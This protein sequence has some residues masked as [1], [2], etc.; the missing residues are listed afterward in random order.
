MNGR[1]LS[2]AIDSTKARTTTPPIRSAT[3]GDNGANRPRP[4]VGLGFDER[5]GW[6]CRRPAGRRDRRVLDRGLSGVEPGPS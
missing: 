6:E 2:A 1:T 3:R 5:G 4:T